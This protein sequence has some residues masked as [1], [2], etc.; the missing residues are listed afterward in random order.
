LQLSA[1]AANE[2]HIFVT[3]HK[4]RKIAVRV[5]RLQVIGLKLKI[6]QFIHKFGVILKTVEGPGHLTFDPDV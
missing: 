3:L 5:K 4:L 2:L 6:S 1:H